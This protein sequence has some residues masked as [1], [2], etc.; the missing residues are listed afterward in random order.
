[1][2]E[3]TGKGGKTEEMFLSCPPGSERLATALTRGVTRGMLARR[4]QREA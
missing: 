4:N 2:K 3:T 1:M